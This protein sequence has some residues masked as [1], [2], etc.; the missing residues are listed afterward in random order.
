[1]ENTHIA[2]TRNKI[3][4]ALWTLGSLVAVAYAWVI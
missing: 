1:M 2:S 4:L 3:E